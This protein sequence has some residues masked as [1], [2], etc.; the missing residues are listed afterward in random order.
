V[1]RKQKRIL[2]WLL[3]W[4][5]LLV[6]VLYSP[7]GSPDL[8]APTNYYSEN[9]GVTFK[10][11]DFSNAPRTV[12]GGNRGNF[13]IPQN[14]SD[15]NQHITTTIDDAKNKLA[16]VQY[17]VG[18]QTTTPVN[19]T[20]AGTTVGAVVVGTTRQN[21]SSGD[22]AT[23]SGVVA[24]NTDFTVLA[25]RQQSNNYTPFSGATD[26]GDAP[27]GPP[28]PIGDGWIFLLLLAVGYTGW[29]KFRL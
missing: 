12:S 18:A 20:G 5:G 26:P 3:T 13:S 29:K 21:N 27:V 28:I 14:N 9:H 19:K 8:Y 23:S 2:V 11:V 15:I 17:S 10:D 24:M 1:N 22:N 16:P 6:A 7:V 4:A 25:N